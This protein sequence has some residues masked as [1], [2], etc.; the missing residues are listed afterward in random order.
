MTKLQIINYFIRWRIFLLVVILVAVLFLPSLPSYSILRKTDNPNFIFNQLLFSWANF[1]GIHYLSIANYNYNL[2][3]RFFPFYP[4]LIHFFSL[5][6]H[7]PALSIGQ[8]LV[9]LTISNLSFL[10]GLF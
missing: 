10:G 5:L 8:L 2:D 6:L 9:A 4:I 1:D 3:G 7:T